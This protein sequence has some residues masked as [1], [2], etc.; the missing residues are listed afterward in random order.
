MSLINRLREW[1]NSGTIITPTTVKQNTGWVA[2]E[3]PAYEYFNWIQNK[4]DRSNN[5]LIDR[6]NQRGFRSPS[7]PQVDRLSQF[8]FD[9]RNWLHPFSSLNYVDTSPTY[10]FVNLC[11]G[12]NYTINREVV[13]AIDYTDYTRIVEIRNDPEAFEIEFSD[14]AINLG[15]PGDQWEALC[16]DGPYIYLLGHTGAPNFEVQVAK[17]SVN[18]WSATP[19][20]YRNFGTGYTIYT[21]RIGQ[22]AIISADSDNLAFLFRGAD[23]YTDTG[24]VVC[25]LAKDNSTYSIGRGNALSSSLY[26]ASTGLCSDGSRVFFAIENETTPDI[27][28]LCAADIS[29]PTQATGPGGPISQK[30]FVSTETVGSILYDGNYVLALSNNMQLYA[31]QVSNDFWTSIGQAKSISDGISLVDD[32]PKMVF[33]GMRIWAILNFDDSGTNYNSFI[34]GFSSTNLL[35]TDTSQVIDFKKVFLSSANPDDTVLAVNRAIFSDGCLWI[36][37]DL[38]YPSDPADTIMRVPNL[39]NR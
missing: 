39:L 15:A 36:L 18:P 38:S 17:Y 4:S 37:P 19:I 34:E 6:A 9:Q 35:F 1:A 33:D 3:Q 2:A 8:Y 7:N 21:S 26:M 25:I 28:F 29:D 32:R 30:S 20:F 22:N 11:S 23:A 24:N 13:Y 12:W 5:Q 16:S 27:S 31:Y 10:R 14:H